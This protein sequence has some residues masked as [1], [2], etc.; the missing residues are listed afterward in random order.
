MTE[1]AAEREN[2]LV[3]DPAWAYPEVLSDGRGGAN[4]WKVGASE[5]GVAAA[6][7]TIGLQGVSQGSGA[8]DV[9][10]RIMVTPVG[11][12]ECSRC[13]RDHRRAVR[14]HELV[15]AQWTP[16][17]EERAELTKKTD[18]VTRPSKYE[19]AVEE[20]RVNQMMN[21]MGLGNAM[22]CM[23]LTNP[24]APASHNAAALLSAIGTPA[25]E[26]SLYDFRAF[27]KTTIQ[28]LR[29]IA[30]RFK[31][32]DEVCDCDSGEQSKKAQ[33]NL[34]LYESNVE[35]TEKVVELAQD[36]LVRLPNDFSR[37]DLW[38]GDRPGGY[39]WTLRLAR[40]V[41]RVFPRDP[42]SGSGGGNGQGQGDPPK[43]DA[44][45]GQCEAGAL[46]EA[47]SHTL[48]DNKGK[49]NPTT[50]DVLPKGDWL[51]KIPPLHDPTGVAW[52]PAKI[53][54]PP[55][56]I[57]T[58]EETVATF[59]RP[60]EE[61]SHLAYPHRWAVDRGVFARRRRV[62]K[63]FVPE[64]AVL[65]DV[66]GSMSW[67]VAALTRMIETLP[68][69]TV[70][71]YSGNVK[72]GHLTIIA[73]E[74]YRVDLENHPL[75]TLGGNGIDGPALEWLGNQAEPRIWLSDGMAWGNRHMTVDTQEDARQRA[76]KIGAAR[77]RSIPD[78]IELLES[79]RRKFTSADV[80][81]VRN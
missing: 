56:T 43:S 29:D 34:D 48:T 21:R 11:V 41:A 2:E 54:Q 9:T 30:E 70:A 81:K 42:P 77:V 27:S 80:K 37:P 12:E 58:F 7:E 69:G 5:Q 76:I 6:A 17:H 8:T 59:R 15:H 31:Q 75:E 61:G 68:A 25:F 49:G 38:R 50:T 46:S 35:A 52:A 24:M 45:P 74:G 32:H 28:Q 51:G 3:A 14:N 23:P 39:K 67:D 47:A 63:K 22:T 40:A 53:I 66:S 72:G 78:A 10:K 79:G 62:K 4:T 55:R 65:I 16:T 73:A 26:S 60:V 18:P 20:I 64:G 19:T 44:R 1:E 71:I 13:G 33:E 57:K 36:A